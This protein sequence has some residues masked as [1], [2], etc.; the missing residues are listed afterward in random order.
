M[1]ELG[2]RVRTAIPLLGVLLAVLFLAPPAVTAA[3]AALIIVVGAWEWAAFLG[4]QLPARRIAYAG[5]IALLLLACHWFVPRVV[6]PDAV[7]YVALAWWLLALVW[8][9]RYPTPV[10]VALAALAGILVLVPAWLAIVAIVGVEGRGPGLLLVALATVFG[11]DI[12]AYFAG[13]RFGRVRLAPQVSPGK[14]WEGLFGG[15]LLATGASVGGGLLVGLAPGTSAPLG[16]GVAALSVVGDLTESMFKRSVGAKDS[17][18]LIPGHGGVLDRLDSI[19][20]A[21]PLFA[22]ALSWLGLTTT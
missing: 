6:D 18:Q 1:T 12:G 5:L 8:I 13:R 21:L 19:T 17:S 22:L 11:A 9:L 3:L 14:T 10:P 2:R 7:L 16:L 4:W 20:A 15:L